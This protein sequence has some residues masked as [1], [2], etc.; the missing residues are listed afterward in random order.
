MLL[1]HLHASL[2][3]YVNGL[4]NADGRKVWHN[5]RETHLTFQKSYLARLN[6]THNNPVH[7]GLVRR[8]ADYEWCS[9]RSFENACSPAWVKTVNFFQFTEVSKEDGDDCVGDLGLR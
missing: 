5:Y 1:K 6:Y 9:A 4:D 8:A 3:R 7:H 2:S